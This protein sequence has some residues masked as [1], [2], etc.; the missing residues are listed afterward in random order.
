MFLD[1]EDEHVGIVTD[2]TTPALTDFI[3]LIISSYLS[4]PYRDTQCGYA[5]SDHGSA[6]RN[7]F[8]GS[9]VIESEF[10]RLTSIFTAPWIL[11][12]D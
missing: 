4:I 10:K 6:T 8:P 3:K 2:Y 12:T 11:W 5:C 7:G 1:P 9:F